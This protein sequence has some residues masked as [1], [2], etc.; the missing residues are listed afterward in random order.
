MYNL[1]I[2]NIRHDSS[3]S[4]K[5]I[6]KKAPSLLERLFHFSF[7]IARRRRAGMSERSDEIPQSSPCEAMFPNRDSICR[8]FPQNAY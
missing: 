1:L 3:L 5:Q 2:F 6:M 7:C 8:I 4:A